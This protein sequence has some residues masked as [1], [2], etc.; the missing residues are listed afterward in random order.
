VLLLIISPRQFSLRPQEATER[1]VFFFAMSDLSTGLRFYWVE[2][3]AGDDEHRRYWGEL[4]ASIHRLVFVREELDAIVKLSDIKLALERL[5]YHME[6]F[7]VRIYE[8]RERAAKLVATCGRL[9]GDFRVLKACD[10]REIAVRELSINQLA[11][12]LYLELVDILNDD[13]DLRNQNTHDTF[14]SLG[15]FSGDNFWDPVYALLDL[16]TDE[17]IKETLRD[18]IDRTVQR[19]GER[20]QRIIDVTMKLLEHLHFTPESCG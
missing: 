3:N 12:D 8:L 7:L 1:G 15:Y 6:N 10:R 14:L 18:E 2:P 19:Y 9:K 13:I 4:C 17:R 5:A 11:Q 20:I 16:E